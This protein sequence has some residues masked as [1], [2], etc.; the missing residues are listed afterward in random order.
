VTATLAAVP[1]TAGAS[2][3]VALMLYLRALIRQPD[4]LNS[5][6]TLADVAG[7]RNFVA[8]TFRDGNHLTQQAKELNTEKD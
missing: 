3:V 2:T 6:S 1:V 5:L 7:M 4:T 8:R